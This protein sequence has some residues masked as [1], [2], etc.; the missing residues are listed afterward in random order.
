MN[1][2]LPDPCAPHWSRLSG[3]F[4][5]PIENSKIQVFDHDKVDCTCTVHGDVTTEAT[6]DMFGTRHLFVIRVDLV[7]HLQP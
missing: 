5:N 7:K 4:G 1:Y 2:A 6:F 3:A